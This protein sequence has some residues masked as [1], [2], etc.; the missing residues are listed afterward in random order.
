MINKVGLGEQLNDAMM[1]MSAYTILQ[2][3]I[4]DFRDG[5]K[6][7]NRRIITSM[8]LNKTF[9]FTKSATVEGRVMQ[10]HPHGG[11]YGS[12][13]GLV[14]KD[15]NSLPFLT[16]KGSWGQYTSSD[17]QPAAARYTEVKLGKNALEVTKELKEKSV[18]YVPNYDGTIN[19]PEVLPVTYPSILTQS[20]SGIANG[21]A[22][23]ILSYN[24]HELYDM[25]DDILMLRGRTKP[26]YPDFP[27]G[28]T[29]VK[30]DDEALNVIRTGRGSFT[31]RAKIEIDNNK[32]IVTEIPY[33]VKREQIIKKIIELNKRGTLKEVTDVRDGTSFKG[34]KIVITAKKNTD[35]KE[36]IVKLYKLTPLQ[37]KVSANMNVLIDGRLEV[38]GVEELLLNWI[39]WRVS[40]IKRGLNNKLTNMKKDLHILEGLRKIASV[41]EVIRIVRFEDDDKVDQLLM[42]AFNLT[43]EQAEYIGKMT[44]RSLNEKRIQNR[45]KDIEDLESRIKDLEETI[46]NDGLLKVILQRRMMET[47]KEIDA[48]K[49]KTEIITI[50]EEKEKEVHK[51]VKVKEVDNAKYFMCFTKNGW[52]LKGKNKN[53]MESQLIL[54]DEIAQYW[55]VQND[56]NIVLFMKDKSVRNIKVKQIKDKEFV[57]NDALFAECNVDESAL[58]LL[59]FDE[60]HIVKIPI[61]AFVKNRQ[62]MEKGYFDGENLIYV[63]QLN[64]EKLINIFIGDKQKPK[65]IEVE[66]INIKKNRLARGQKLFNNKKLEKV[67]VTLG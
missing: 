43:E 14:Q 33:G 42:E 48:P 22:T 25:I 12:I 51:I 19:V 64:G 41:D 16:G 38:L 45:L 26:I 24:I 27:T 10:L 58:V 66:T 63:K 65:T 56:K 21:F 31:M 28:A 6:P 20:Q 52:L 50:D 5:F 3:A 67:N 46:D 13:V 35:M 55:E 8:L 18:D 2:R 40:V 15:R 29:I 32:L 17:Q 44:L 7:V 36:L 37:A 9:N 57:G 23:S 30:D 53:D 1:G 49:R 4:P 39:K 47:M 62:I 34:M 54:G 59:V 11:S 60:G 61:D